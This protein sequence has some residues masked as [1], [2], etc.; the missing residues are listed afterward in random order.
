MAANVNLTSK[1]NIIDNAIIIVIQSNQI[2]ISPVKIK[3]LV[4]STS[5]I[6][7]EIT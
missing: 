6:T 3:S 5:L 2:F 4:C 7:L 1:K